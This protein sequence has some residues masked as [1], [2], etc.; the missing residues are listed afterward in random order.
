[1]AFD[2]WGKGTAVTV[3]SGKKTI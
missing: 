3:T 2:Y 1:G